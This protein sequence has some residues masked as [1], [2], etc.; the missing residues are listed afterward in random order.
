MASVNGQ[1]VRR[2][3]LGDARREAGEKEIERYI[4]HCCIL[5]WRLA[6]RKGD[7]HPRTDRY[8]GTLEKHPYINTHPIRWNVTPSAISAAVQR[9]VSCFAQMQKGCL[10]WNLCE[11]CT[12]AAVQARR[13]LDVMLEEAPGPASFRSDTTTLATLP[14]SILR[15]PR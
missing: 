3:R 6:A 14:R 15:S 9:K 2:V 10:Y 12:A 1:L 5:K 13:Q 8:R 11:Y 7:S 4:N